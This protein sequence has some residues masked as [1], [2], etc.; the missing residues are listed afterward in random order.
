VPSKKVGK[1][2]KKELCYENKKNK[3]EKKDYSFF[4]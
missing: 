4:R 1:E 2:F 3:P